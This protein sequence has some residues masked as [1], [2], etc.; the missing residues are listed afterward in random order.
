MDEPFR[1]L[2]EADELITYRYEGFWT[3]M[4]TL[5]DLQR[6]RSLYDRGDPPWVRVGSGAAGRTAD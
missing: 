4:D 5:K 2:I 6:L 3:A 1:R